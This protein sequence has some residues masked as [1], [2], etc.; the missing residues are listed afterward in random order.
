VSEEEP[1]GAETPKESKP[2]RPSGLPLDFYDKLKETGSLEQAM[3]KRPGEGQG[4]G[5]T[6]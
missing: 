2:T 1:K 4:S 5:P 6:P 3:G